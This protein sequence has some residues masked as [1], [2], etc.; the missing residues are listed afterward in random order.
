V[1]C[2]D[3]ENVIPEARIQAIPDT[4]YCV[5]CVDKYTEPIV[6]RMIY[7]HKT[8]G[9]VVFAQGKENI[10]RLNREYSRSR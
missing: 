1:K 3:C 8:A 7:N 5:D 10:R 9:E 4:E 6:G 2:F